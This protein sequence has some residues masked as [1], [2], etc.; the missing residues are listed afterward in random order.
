MI[1]G[2]GGTGGNFAKEFCRYVSFLPE[3]KKEQINIVFVDGDIV[4]EKNLA[5]QPFNSDN[6][7]Q[8]KAMS[9]AEAVADNFDLDVSV[10][11]KYITETSEIVD[12]VTNLSGDN[13][14]GDNFTLPIIV[15]CV[16]NH[17][18]RQVFHEYFNS[19]SNCLYIDS[20]NEFESGE[21]ITAAKIKGEIVNPPR[22]FYFPEVLEDKSPNKLEESC[23]AINVSSPQHIMTNIMAGNIILSEI[24]R[25]LEKG[26]I[27]EGIIFF[28]AFKPY[29]TR[30]VPEKKAE[31]SGDNESQ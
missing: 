30:R 1:M 8:S 13:N 4:E 27:E 6:I 11:D 22:G 5:R 16:D 29:I 10:V 17:R 23:G 24:V 14:Y 9:L 28:N 25:F 7:S 26:L 18:A 20:A 2:V 3:E 31:R 12:I 15:G 21:V 19:V